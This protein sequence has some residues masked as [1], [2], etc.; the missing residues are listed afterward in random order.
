MV[1]EGTLGAVLAGGRSRRLGQDKALIS[2]RGTTLVERAV[3]LLGVLFSRVVLVAPRRPDYEAL[4]VER[5][6]DRF[7]DAG[8][9]AGIEAALAAAG[10][11]PVFVLACDLPLVDL[12]LVTAL[13][14]TAVDFGAAGPAARLAAARGVVQPLC[15]LYAAACGPVFTRALEQGVR[16]MHQA[17]REI[18]CQRFEVAPELLLNVNVEADVARLRELEAA[19]AR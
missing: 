9:L 3:S 4:G 10:G 2:S 8:P 17:L 12:D 13:A 19:W 7:P 16:A 11:Q 1:I 18:S 14:T 15:G 6:A 5:I